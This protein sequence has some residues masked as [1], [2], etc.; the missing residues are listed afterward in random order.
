M[1]LWK[2][3]IWRGHIFFPSRNGVFLIAVLVLSLRNSRHFSAIP[4]VGAKRGLQESFKWK[5]MAPACT[6]PDQLTLMRGFGN[7]LDIKNCPAW[8]TCNG[9]QKATLNV[10]VHQLTHLLQIRSFIPYLF[11]WRKIC[12][13]LCWKKTSTQKKTFVPSDSSGGNEVSACVSTS[14]T[15]ISF[16]LERLRLFVLVFS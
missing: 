1:D 14:S 4:R 5:P 2:R 16:W 8:T 3:T 9:Y 11:F 13:N 12:Q 10:D 7:I 15:F 6:A